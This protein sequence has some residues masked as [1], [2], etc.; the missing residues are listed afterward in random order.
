MSF[1]GNAQARR[2]DRAAESVQ[3]LELPDVETVSVDGLLAYKTYRITGG[4]S[5]ILPP[6]SSP[7]GKFKVII[8]FNLTGV[9]ITITSNGL[10][11]IRRD[12][13]TTGTTITIPA[14]QRCTTILDCSTVWEPTVG[15]TA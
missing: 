15:F 11:Q 2:L 1:D 12:G 7:I 5:Y 8:I 3:A 9:S 6:L 4:T 10:D 13:L 14:G